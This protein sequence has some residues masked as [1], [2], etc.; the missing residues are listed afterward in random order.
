MC[1]AMSGLGASPSEMP[2]SA[3]PSG[4]GRE[5]DEPPADMLPI[6][7]SLPGCPEQLRA[8]A[9][10]LASPAGRP[11]RGQ[12]AARLAFARAAALVGVLPDGRLWTQRTL[13][14]PPART[15]VRLAASLAT[16]SVG[17]GGSARWRCHDPAES[18]WLVDGSPLYP[19]MRQQYMTR[20]DA[21]RRVHVTN[22]IEMSVHARLRWDGNWK[23]HCR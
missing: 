15:Y 19:H 20:L 1:N 17:P 4:P 10:M 13:P 12:A 11:A 14:W 9:R 6:G 5:L 22:M 23:T 7:Q 2:I 8:V 16:A 18:S 3:F 21:D